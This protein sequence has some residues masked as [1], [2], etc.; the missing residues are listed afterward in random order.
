VRDGFAILKVGP[1][2]TFAM[3]EALESLSLIEMELVPPEQQSALMEVLERVMLNDRRYWKD[4]YFGDER[5]QRILRRYSYSDRVRYYWNHPDAKRAVDTLVFNLRSTGIP[6][7]VLA[8]FMPEQY[9]A[10]RAGRLKPD[11]E[12]LVQHRIRNVLRVYAEACRTRIS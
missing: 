11:P 6:E 1:A 7:T 8:T 10:V 2:L 12:A 5:A 3:R 9:G 4:H